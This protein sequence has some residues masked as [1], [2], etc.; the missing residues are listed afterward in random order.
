MNAKILKLKHITPVEKMVLLLVD[1]WNPLFTAF[2]M[3]SQ[4]IAT[5]LGL[6][7]KQVL[8]ALGALI[9][10]DYI[11]CEVGYRSRITKIT[12]RFEDL[13]KPQN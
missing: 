2:N 9:E 11:E 7:R 12:K 3:T 10:H 13:I 4:E 8:D 5:E 1:E 6:T